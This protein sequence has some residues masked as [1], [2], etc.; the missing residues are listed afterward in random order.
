MS[1]DFYF[2]IE[3]DFLYY[4]VY[5]K[6]AISPNTILPHL[7][8]YRPRITLDHLYQ[9]LQTEKKDFPILHELLK[10]VSKLNFIIMATS[11][12]EEAWD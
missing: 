11:V 4:T 10:E 8:S 3:Q 1:I 7:W 5:E 12:C 2:S 9:I 6:V